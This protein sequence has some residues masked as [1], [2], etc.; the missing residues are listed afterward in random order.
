MKRFLVNKFDTV[1]LTLLMALMLS[2]NVS[3]PATAAQADLP[4]TFF[5]THYEM[6]GDPNDPEGAQISLRWQTLCQS[7]GWLEGH[8]LGSGR[9]GSLL[10]KPPE[11]GGQ[12]TIEDRLRRGHS[13]WS[14]GE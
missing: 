11:V 3:P 6:L 2:N 7:A 12:Y 1:V 13:R 10:A 5:F 9:V 4:Y 14:H 8:P